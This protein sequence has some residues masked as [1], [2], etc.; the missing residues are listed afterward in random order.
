[1][2]APCF[3][4][5]GAGHA[6]TA[7]ASAM[8]AAGFAG[9]IVMIGDDPHLPYE[10]P[11]LSKEALRGAD[12]AAPPIYPAN[13]YADRA[14]ELKLGQGA[15]AI[16]PGAQV[17]TLTDGERI[18]FDKLL[19]A[20]GARARRYPLLD[21]L[22]EAAHVLR[23]ADDARRLRAE[24]VPGRRL[25]VVGGGVIGLEVAATAS[26]LGLSVEVIERAP[27]LLARGAPQPLADLLAQAH[28]DHDVALH[29]GVDLADA[30]REGGM[31]RLT[32]AEGREFV[33]DLVVYGIGVTLN[34]ELAAAAGLAMDD[35]ILVDAQGRT[36]HPAIY[37]AGDIARQEQAFLGGAVRQETWANALHQG[38]AAARAMVTGE[39][40][41]HEVPWYWTD[42]FG[43]N[44]QVAGRIAAEQW[45]TRMGPDG[46]PRMVFGLSQGVLTGAVGVDAG[47]DMRILRKLIAQGA[48]VD[49]AVLADPDVALRKMGKEIQSV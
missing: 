48:R 4:I 5:L 39:A 31:V 36:S 13:F 43:V 3:V 23:S 21:A 17:V 18:G 32:C 49:P 8:R 16:D 24:L 41:A 45:I 26:A 47:A 7:A 38:A 14:I 29:C 42:Q 6:G 11:P 46:R 1:M 19:I 25:L 37:A 44:Y 27:R 2:T 12:G 28:R 22:G 30:S 10:R 33:G 15:T 35:G 34:D 20:T 9:R 40:G